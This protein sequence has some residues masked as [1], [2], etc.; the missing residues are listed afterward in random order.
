VVST[1]SAEKDDKIVLTETLE[2]RAVDILTIDILSNEAVKSSIAA[3]PHEE[4]NVVGRRV[5]RTIFSKC[6]RSTTQKEGLWWWGN[7]LSPRS[8]AEIDSCCWSS[9]AMA[10]K[11]TDAARLLHQARKVADFPRV[12]II[13]DLICSH[14]YSVRTINLELWSVRRNARRTTRPA[15][16]AAPPVARSAPSV[17]SRRQQQRT[18]R[19]ATAAL[20]AAAAGRRRE[21]SE[22]TGRTQHARLRVCEGELR[23]S[24][25]SG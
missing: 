5:F 3:R 24:C 17:H 12:L 9:A 18:S 11:L 6:Q 13:V 20:D 2:S 4:S 23:G 16:V 14:F 19:M 7:V 21:S 15:L 22:S 8:A 25:G 10:S 1:L